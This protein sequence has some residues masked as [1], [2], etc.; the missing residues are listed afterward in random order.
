MAATTATVRLALRGAAALHGILGTPMMETLAAGAHR[1]SG[2]RIPLWNRAMPRAAERLTPYPPAGA[3]AASVEGA[4][5]PIPHSAVPAYDVSARNVAPGRGRGQKEKVVYFPSCITR[6]MGP[7]DIGRPSLPTLTIGL[8]GRAGYEVALPA[9]VDGL[10]CGMAFASKGFDVEGRRKA[11]ELREAML[12]ASAGG[13]LPILMDMSPCLY[14][15]R[16]E[17]GDG[18]RLYD[19]SVFAL[20]FVA[21]RLKLRHVRDTVAVHA[22]CS[23]RKLGIAPSLEKLAGMCSQKVVTPKDV[24]CCGW[25]GD[26][27]FS[28]PELTASALHGLRESLPAECAAG[29]STSRTCEIGLSLHGGVPYEGILYLVDE[30]SR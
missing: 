8:L 30:A 5:S 25:A 9:D 6:T 15:M 20:E 22:T 10:C 14:R 1:I 2:R 29:Y 21:P 28:F 19:Q 13:R 18:L 23:A 7:A 17:F 24:G 26:R 27:G 4:D 11:L 12:D 3:L 16:P